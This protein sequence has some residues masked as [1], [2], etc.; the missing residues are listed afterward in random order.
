M[1]KFTSCNKKNDNRNNI[2]KIETY[3]VSKRISIE[4]D[5]ISR[6]RSHNNT[7]LAEMKKLKNEKMT[8]FLCLHRESGGATRLQRRLLCSFKKNGRAC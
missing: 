1:H 7:L 6:L 8:W 2:N 4:E 5:E 3:N